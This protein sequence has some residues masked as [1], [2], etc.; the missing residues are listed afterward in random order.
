MLVCPSPWD[1][2]PN[3][4]AVS[5]AAIAAIVSMYAAYRTSHV[6][7]AVQAALS[8]RDTNTK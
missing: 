5:L 2:G 1:F 7:A 4:L 8:A 6:A 3:V